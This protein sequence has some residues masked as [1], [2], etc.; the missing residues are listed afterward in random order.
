MAKMED[1]ELLGLLD[2]F[3]A[4]AQ[5]MDS[6]DRSQR[7]EDAIAF[8]DGNK[9]IVPIEPNKSQVVSPDLADALEWIKPGLQRVFLNSNHVGIYEP[10]SEED[11]EGAEQ[12]TD[13]INFQFLRRCNGYAVVNDGIHDGLLHGNGIWKHWWDKSKQYKTETLTGLTEEEYEALL[14]DDTVEE[15]LEKRVYMV[16]PDGQELKDGDD[17]AY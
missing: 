6:S 10:S 2:G 3:I 11:E 7:R 15:V 14:D 8:Q 13:G 9:S 5:Q 17:A 4:D 16:G 12:A 1:R